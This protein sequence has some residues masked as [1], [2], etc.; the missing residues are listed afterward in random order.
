M[1]VTIHKLLLTLGIVAAL[2]VFTG[3]VIPFIQNPGFLNVLPA[4]L[5]ILAFYLACL[6]PISIWLTIGLALFSP[7]FLLLFLCWLFRRY[8]RKRAEREVSQ[9][10]EQLYRHFLAPVI[11]PQE[12]PIPLMQRRFRH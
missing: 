3:A 4:I 10:M 2:I 11:P 5:A 7:A 1:S 9:R 12:K 6:F 8:K